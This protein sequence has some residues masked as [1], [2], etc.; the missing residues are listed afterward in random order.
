MSEAPLICFGQQPCGFFPRRFL[1]AKIQTARRLQSEIGG[2]IVFFYHDSDHDPRETQT[3]LRHR[4]TGEEARLNFTFA[5]KLQR[6]WCP[7]FLK[8][9]LSEWGPNLARQL[10]VYVEDRWVEAFR[11]I[12]AANVADFCLE[13]YQAMGLLE[14]IRVAR[15]GE[16][17]FRREAC[18]VPDFFVDLPYLGEIVRARHSQGS[19]LLHEGGDS[20]V[21][22][23]PIAF[24][25]EQISPARDSRLRWMQS[26]LHCT[27][28]V[29]GAGEQAYLRCRD[30]P[31]I[32]FVRRDAIDRSDEAYTDLPG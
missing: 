14:G 15:S 28:Y 1:F 18:E 3:I 10:P 9:V 12:R 30:M 21:T 19:L 16:P 32:A 17:S 20:Y 22:V 4:R 5:N 23:P 6:K 2:E 8:R 13:M 27:H 31:E 7:L 24:N 11:R 29:T 25:K 26:V